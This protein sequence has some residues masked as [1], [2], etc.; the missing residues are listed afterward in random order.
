VALL[1]APL[2]AQAQ[3][4]KRGLTPLGNPGALVEA[5]AALAHLA[6]DRGAGAAM[7]AMADDAAAVASAPAS[8][9]RS[10]LKAH[11]V[12]PWFADRRTDAVYAACDGTAGISTGVWRGGW[13]ALVWKR[14]KKLDFKWLLADAGTLD[15]LPPPPDW[16]TGKLADCPPRGD[17]GTPPPPPG[18][19]VLRPL[20]AAMP[21]IDAPAGAPVHDGRSND[22]SLVWR[23]I[24]LPDGTHRL[25]AWFWQDGAWRVALDQ[26]GAG[27]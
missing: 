21:A 4:S 27:E 6:R 19:P 8:P 22:G 15:V 1:L 9:A 5:D 18:P 23:T 3:S 2:A 11:N 26:R 20:P 14:Q 13:F 7:A 25:L 10:W 16:I 17:A 24:D 12:A